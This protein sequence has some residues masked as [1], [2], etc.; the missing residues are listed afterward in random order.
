MDWTERI[1]SIP[2]SIQTGDGKT[3][4]PLWKGGEKEKE[5][6]TSSFEFINVYGTLVDRKKPQGGKFPLVFWFQGANN[7]EQADEF[8]ASC[9]DSRAWNVVHPFYGA[10]LGQ[11]ISIKRDDSSLNVTEITIPFWE[12]IDADYPISNFSVKD[13]TMDRHRTVLYACSTSFVTNLK[14]SFTAIPTA[15]NSIQSIA[16]SMKSIQ[17]N[18]TY[19]D[20][21]NAL[22]SGLKAIDNLTSD[23]LTAIQS[24]Q[25]FLDLPSTYIQAIEGRL[26]SYENVYWNLKNSIKSLKSL[27][28]KKYFES[29]GGS[30][31]ACISLVLV[32]P[33]VGDY[34][35]I[36]D[37]ENKAS[38][39]K[40]IYDDYLL[41]L[42]SLAVSVYNVN[43]SF[44][45]DATAQSE[46][47]SLIIY[48]IANLQQLAFETKKEYIIYTTKKT[49]LILLVHRYLGLDEAGVNM[50]IF[51]KTNNIK[52]NELFSI[53]KG[54]EIRYTK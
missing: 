43:N 22:N 46:I 6:N 21:Q 17:D 35:L 1:D 51:R 27:A 30:V 42:D 11:P 7:T 39:L 52:L 40:L 19:A 28:D 29:I 37:V 34:V 24:V 16:G 10:I 25:N 48:T 44:T 31:L 5:F 54:R 36:S 53:D 41:T 33:V 12:T 13:N 8:E 47:S 45:P 26:G 49:N 2:F 32:T 38:R 50:D 23:A 20:F 18:N 3:Y 14:V 15:A 4:F 9:D